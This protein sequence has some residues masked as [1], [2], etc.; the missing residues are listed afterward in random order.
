MAWSMR[1]SL[2]RLLL[3]IKIT[4]RVPVGVIGGFFCFAR[5]GGVIEDNH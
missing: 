4:I 3:I 1:E 5:C 2:V